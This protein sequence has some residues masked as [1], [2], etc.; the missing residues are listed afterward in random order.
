[1][2]Q[3][4]LYAAI[5]SGVVATAG[6]WWFRLVLKNVRTLPNLTRYGVYAFIWLAYFVLTMTLIDQMG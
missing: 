1:M 2:A 5:S 3:E 4:T 6:L